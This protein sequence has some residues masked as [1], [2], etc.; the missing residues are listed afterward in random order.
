MRI[1]EI[2]WSTLL[3][4]VPS[5]SILEGKDQQQISFRGKTKVILMGQKST[6]RAHG[7]DSSQA[8]NASHAFS[9]LKECVPVGIFLHE[10]I[11]NSASALTLHVL[12]FSPTL[13]FK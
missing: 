13:F 9:C 4:P 5:P 10:C 1:P 2:R 8:K 6:S 3:S 7:D 11:K 12:L